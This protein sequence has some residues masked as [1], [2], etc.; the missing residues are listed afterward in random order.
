[1]IDRASGALG[2]TM[3]A[4]PNSQ[5]VSAGATPATVGCGNLVSTAQ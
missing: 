5:S 2:G 4:P 1:M 3:T